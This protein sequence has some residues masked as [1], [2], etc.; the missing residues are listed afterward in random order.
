MGDDCDPDP[1]NDGLPNDGDPCP[2]IP[3]CDGDGVFDITD[4]CP[5]HSNPD[6]HDDD[7]DGIGDVCE[8]CVLDPAGCIDRLALDLLP[9]GTP[10][11][12][13]ESV[14][15]VESCGEIDDND[16]L[17]ADE[18]SIDA[19]TIDVVVGPIGVPAASGVTG[20][21]LALGYDISR[22]VV[23]ASELDH[24][25]AVNPG[26]SLFDA[27]EDLPDLD[28]MY[29]PSAVDMGEGPGETGDGVIARITIEAIGTVIS[30]MT[31]IVIADYG[32]LDNSGSVLDAISTYGGAIALNST[33]DVPDSDD[34]SIPDP[35]DNCPNV[36]NS[37]QRDNE[38]D[39]IGDKCDPDDDNAG[40]F[41]VDEIACGADPFVPSNRPER[42][43]GQFNGTDDNGNGQ[44]D[45]PP[46]PGAEN[47]DCDG[48]GFSGV[49][50]NHVYAPETRADQDPCGTH[51]LPPAIT[52]ATGWPADLAGGSFSMAKVNI[53]DLASY[54]APIRHI[55]TDV[56]TLARDNRWDLVPG[57]GAIAHD[58]NVQDLVKIVTT[59]PPMLG[60]AR[61]FNGPVCPWAP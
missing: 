4:N 55:N 41:D 36:Q 38:Q 2:L 37:S 40:V 22:L 30:S 20:F 21:Q 45:E 16:F 23:R 39:G 44:I 32:V 28:G 59:F 12:S 52:P 24:L 35:V 33:C 26:S 13:P 49:E 6:Q 42:I 9:G 8:P 27:S 15:S 14:G 3:E 61:A 29:L 46:P 17:D 48:D 1:D 54:V 5:A 56:S 18:S 11:N 19:L 34:D 7:F 25:L 10:P 58:I 31:P 51:A 60:G 53:S 57:N 47:Y 50:E 43:D